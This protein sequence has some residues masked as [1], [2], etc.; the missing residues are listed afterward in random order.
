VLD[1]VRLSHPRERLQF[2]FESALRRVHGRQAV[3]NELTLRPLRERHHVLAIGK[4]AVAMA[5]GAVD[6]LGDCVASG[7]VVTVAGAER[8]SPFRCL[9]GGHPLPDESSL[10]AGDAVWRYCRALPPDEAVLVLISG[11]TSALVERLVDGVSLETFREQSRWLLGSGLPIEAVNAV[12][13]RWS[14][15]KAGGLRQWLGARPVRQFLISDVP[16]DEPRVI[17]SGPLIPGLPTLPDSLPEALRASLLR[18]DEGPPNAWATETRLVARNADALRAAA[19]QADAEGYRVI[20]SA[21]DLVG[22]AW[23]AGQGCARVL[24][25]GPPGLYLWG[26][27]TTVRL[28]PSPGRGGRNQHLAL[29]AANVLAGIPDVWLLAAGTD[30]RDGQSEAAGALVDGGSVARAAEAGWQVESARQQAS[31][32]DWLTASGDLLDTGPTGTNVMDLVIALK[33]PN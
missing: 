33:A 32:G 5:Q 20:R 8:D 7:L 30:G 9:I 24:R 19:D 29:A 17:G 28:P 3:L 2:W 31:S 16:G 1:A 21:S 6:G 15:F 10:L 14:G 27:E 26:G 18:R 22:D 25:D 12:R 13:A 11:G 4:A 23:E